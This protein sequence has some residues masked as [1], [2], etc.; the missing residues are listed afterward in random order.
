MSP[1]LL[2]CAFSC[3]YPWNSRIQLPAQ[4]PRVNREHE[5]SI[6]NLPA[7]GLKCRVGQLVVPSTTR[8]Q[9]CRQNKTADWIDQLLAVTGL[10]SNGRRTLCRFMIFYEICVG[11]VGQSTAKL[12]SIHFMESIESARKTASGNIHVVPISKNVGADGLCMFEFFEPEDW[13]LNTVKGYKSFPIV[14]S[15]VRHPMFESLGWFFNLQ[16]LTNASLGNEAVC[17]AA[18]SLFDVEYISILRCFLQ[19]VWFVSVFV[20]CWFSVFLK[21]KSMYWYCLVLSVTIDTTALTNFGSRFGR[22]ALRYLTT[23]AMEARVIQDTSQDPRSPGLWM[24]LKDLV[25]FVDA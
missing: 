19:L 3:I 18:V 6:H 11:K 15:R 14:Y 22:S 7:L 12:S 16:L 17:H 8:P 4:Q 25:G 20:C 13:M 2:Q 5:V 21:R 9:I 24:T 10:W 1:I 23:L